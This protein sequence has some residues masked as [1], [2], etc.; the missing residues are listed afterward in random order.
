MHKLLWHR[1]LPDRR[2]QESTERKKIILNIGVDKRNKINGR[3]KCMQSVM[4]ESYVLSMA[5]P[6]WVGQIISSGKKYRYICI[7]PF[8]D[9]IASYYLKHIRMMIHGGF[10]R[11]RIA[12]AS[13]ISF[14][15][16]KLVTDCNGKTQSVHTETNLLLPIKR[17]LIF[18]PSCIWYKPIVRV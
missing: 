2:Q 3:K 11:S 5:K 18:F 1:I 16:W 15:R 10:S 17:K 12:P 4:H 6:I 7:Y 9:I 14:K 8:G 13:A